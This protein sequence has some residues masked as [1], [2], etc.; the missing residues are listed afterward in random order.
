VEE[1]LT[2]INKEIIRLTKRLASERRSPVSDPDASD[3]RISDCHER[4]KVLREIRSQ[5]EDVYI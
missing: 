4:I 2:V 3:E 1:I 5:I